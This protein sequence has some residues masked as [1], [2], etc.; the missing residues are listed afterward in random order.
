MEKFTFIWG[1]LPLFG[2]NKVLFISADGSAW[3]ILHTSNTPPLLNS[4]L[5]NFSLFPN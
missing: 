3:P 2:G 4:Q 5:L 1:E